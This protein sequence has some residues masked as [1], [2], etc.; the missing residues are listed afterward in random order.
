M[1]E[2]VGIACSA[3]HGCAVK[4]A[5]VCQ[6]AGIVDRLAQDGADERID[7][8]GV[9]VFHSPGDVLDH[10]RDLDE[11]GTGDGGGLT[12]DGAFGL[13]AIEGDGKGIFLVVVGGNIAIVLFPQMK[14]LVEE[15]IRPSGTVKIK[16]VAQAEVAVADC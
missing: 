8:G 5:E 11:V 16:D 12:T 13:L 3:C 10:R 6:S 2:V 15:I 4:D 1:D 7:E 9:A 14:E